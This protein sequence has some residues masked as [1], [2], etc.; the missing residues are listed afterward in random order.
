[1]AAPRCILPALGQ[2]LS[3]FR[4][5]ALLAAVLALFRPLSLTAQRSDPFF[6]ETKFEE[7]ERAGP[8]EEVPWKLRVI[9]GG[10][11][12]H[13]RLVGHCDI[14]VDGRYF[15]QRPE[16][17]D[18]IAMVQ[19]RD[20]AGNVYQ[21]HD[22]E[23]IDS[24][25]PAVKDGVFFAWHAFM[26]PGEYR[27]AV[28]LYDESTGKRSF[29]RRMLRIDPL[30]K[31]PL[32]EVWHDLPTVEFVQVRSEQPDA[33]FH[34][35]IQ[36]RLRLPVRTLRPIRIELMANLTGTGRAV[37]SHS[38]YN[39]NIALLMPIMK[40]FSQLE[41]EK[42]ALNVEFLDLV[43]RQVAFAQDDARILDWPRLKAAV[44]AADPAKIDVHALE[45]T[46]HSALFLRREVA[47]KI[48]SGA[49]PPDALPVVILISSAAFFE[50]LDDIND[51]LLPATCRCVVYYIGYNPLNLRFHRAVYDFDNVKKVLKPLSVRTHMAQAP[52]DLRR[53]LAEIMD[54]IS[55]M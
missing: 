50:R 38:A 18:L 52:E 3:T 53:I 11:T 10:L 30:G 42:G 49:G 28:A 7:W 43:R 21:D 25:S 39:F 44:K 36:G 48:E 37:V 35:E 26:L 41:V 23:F 5:L 22:T 34:P 17:G 1:V 51:T 2:M 12:V 33:S 40:S 9:P 24:K 31:D 15:K 16:P 29:A 13:Q 6:A 27:I 8:V 32:P 19:V 4:V 55:K 45:D 54:E 20:A 47:R 46:K 14:D